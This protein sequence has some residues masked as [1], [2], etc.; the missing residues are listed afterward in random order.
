MGII[1]VHRERFRGAARDRE[2]VRRVLGD[3]LVDAGAAVRPVLEEGL[4]ERR[5]LD[6]G[7]GDRV[8]ANRQVRPLVLDHGLHTRLGTRDVGPGHGLGVLHRR[9]GCRGIVEKLL[10]ET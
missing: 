1:V 8:R 4:E 5:R 2:R 10:R 9:A 3:A 7:G 6:H